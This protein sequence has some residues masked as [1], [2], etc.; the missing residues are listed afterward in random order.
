M[1]WYPNGYTPLPTHTPLHVTVNETE[2]E[3]VRSVEGWVRSDC[4]FEGRSFE[5][6]FAE[7][8]RLVRVLKMVVKKELVSNA[9]GVDLLLLGSGMRGLSRKGLRGVV[10]LRRVLDPEAEITWDWKEW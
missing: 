10:G 9:G 7:D 5:I 2:E 6:I 8:A 1:T 4:R 3:Y